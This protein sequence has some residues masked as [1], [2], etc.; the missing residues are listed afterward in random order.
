MIAIHNWIL[1]IGRTSIIEGA[2]VV[3]AYERHA[4]VRN[5]LSSIFMF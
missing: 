4:T 3:Q 2:Q 1:Y 5:M